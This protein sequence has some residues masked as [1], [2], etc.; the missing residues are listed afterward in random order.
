MATK[1]QHYVPRV[2][3]KA[4]ET[5]VY[6][7]KEPQK[8]FSGVYYYDKSNL[9][10]GDGRN[11]GTILTANHTYTIDFDYTFI[12]PMCREIR[13]EFAERIKD[14]LSKRNV[15]AYYNG[16]AL[17]SRNSI[18]T[19]LPFLEEWTFYNADNTL[20][21]KKAVINSIKEVRSYCLED[22]FGTYVE[23]RWESI[24]Q[25]FLSPFPKD[26]GRGQIEYSFPMSQA[27]VDMLD[28]VALMMCRNPAFDLLGLFSWLKT[29]ILDPIFLQ[30]GNTVGADII[31]RGC[32]L[33]EIYKGLYGK[34][35][36]VNSFLSSAVS[37]LGVMVLRVANEGE[38]SF[39]T[40][41]NPVVY[42]KLLVE[43]SNHNGI[44]FPLTPQFL[45]F[46][47][48]RSD[49][50]VNDV[51]FRTVCNGDIRRLN[52]IILNGA[53][54]GIVSKEQRLGYII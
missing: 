54:L 17:T 48:K 22:K 45:L 26:D 32:W 37:G 1:N 23:T 16:K 38:G 39:I 35:G 2:Y 36:F 43:A 40:S 44:Y 3:T 34:N 50:S 12:L 41:D 33:T 18:S 53:E 14:I 6:S 21:S 47:G 20:A 31:M 7:I 49:G 13:V 4:W 28:M 27:V 5:T 42:H 30:C 52:R 10:M 11:K 24:L 8:P 51:I 25:A 29:D 9:T 15:K 46:L 19:W